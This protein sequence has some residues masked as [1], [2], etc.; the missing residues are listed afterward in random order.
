MYCRNSIRLRILWPIHHH[1]DVWFSHY[2]RPVYLRYDDRVQVETHVFV[3]EVAWQTTEYQC[4]TTY[5]ATRPTE[6]TGSQSPP[7]NLLTIYCTTRFT[8]NTIT[9]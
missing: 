5:Q 3:G 7:V 2:N 6:G 8:L 1:I 9:M 4:Q